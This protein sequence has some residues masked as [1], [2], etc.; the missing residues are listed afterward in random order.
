MKRR[1][2]IKLS[3]ITGFAVLQPTFTYAKGLD[4]SQITFSSSLYNDNN[5]QTII[6]FMYGGAS[7]LS[8]NLSN[9]DAIKSASQS[10]YDSY[11][12]GITPTE[13][14]CWQEAGGTHMET[15]MENG[16]TLS[17]LLFRSKRKYKQ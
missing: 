11:F 7:Q 6:I 5:A 13:N 14:K 1:D 17:L 8:G 4:V 15:L 3:L 12:R 2:F 16:D 9:I 10:D